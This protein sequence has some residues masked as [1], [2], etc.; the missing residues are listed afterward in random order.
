[1]LAQRATQQSLRRLVASR[2]TLASQMVSRKFAAPMAVMGSSLTYRP[3]ATQNLTPKD[4]YEI[5]V[6]QRKNR[7]TSP[8]LTIYKP[9]VPWILSGLNRIT[10]EILSGAVYIFGSAYLIA[11]LMGWHLDS[12]SMA[13]AFASWPVLA[14]IGTKL[15]FAFPFTFHTINGLRHLSWD[16]GRTFKNATVIKTGWTVVGLSTASALAL[17]LLV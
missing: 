14:K 16:L 3:V 6:A 5:L 17:A 9:Q 7:P 10:G 12:A 15:F 4:S 13:A 1:M 2:P 8:H 11:P